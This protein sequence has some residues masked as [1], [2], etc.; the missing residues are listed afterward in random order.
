M[1]PDQGRNLQ[2]LTPD[3]QY[4]IGA[5]VGAQFVI[6][7]TAD[8][9]RWFGDGS[10]MQLAQGGT[11]E[12][13]D[14]IQEYVNFAYTPWLFEDLKVLNDTTVPNPSTVVKNGNQ[15]EVT[16]A[17]KTCRSFVAPQIDTNTRKSADVLIGYRL[18]F[19]VNQYN[20]STA[21]IFVSRANIWY[22]DGY[23]T[24]LFG[25]AF[26]TDALRQKNCEILRDS[27]ETTWNMNFNQADR[28]IDHCVDE[29]TQLATAES[30]TFNPGQFNEV[31]YNGFVDGDTSGCRFLHG[32]F[33]YDNPNHCA[34]ISFKKVSDPNSKKKC[35]VKSTYNRVSP[36]YL[37]DVNNI[38]FFQ[39]VASSFYGIP[40]GYSY[41]ST[42]TCRD[43]H[44]GDYT[45]L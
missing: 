42:E 18:F 22:D 17:V 35:Q 3:Q 25:V 40:G 5:L 24:E 28:T 11:Y 2:D 41:S 33:A 34:H 19:N 8:F 4:C 37:F 43:K 39:Y 44:P 20:G 15:C 36:E 13:L 32:G 29:M 30:A 27:C 38:G 10:I 14:G 23:L 6:T 12:G 9:S 16:V 1:A 7:N 21:E 26:Q 45:S 31:S